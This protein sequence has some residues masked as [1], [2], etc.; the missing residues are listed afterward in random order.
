MT[1]WFTSLIICC[2]FFWMVCLLEMEQIAPHQ[3]L[4][5]SLGQCF[6]RDSVGKSCLF[7]SD[8][9]FLWFTAMPCYC[10]QAEKVIITSA[11]AAVA[12]KF[13]SKLMFSVSTW[14][15]VTGVLIIGISLLELNLGRSALK[16][17]SCPWLTAAG[18]DCLEHKDIGT[19]A[20]LLKWLLKIA[21]SW[22]GNFWRN[23][24]SSTCEFLLV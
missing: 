14:A 3:A 22:E 10:C 23:E 12:A 17:L 15:Y 24:I 8:H 11:R 9:I 7:L 1:V 4:S 6:F 13:P 16:S 5:W 21:S 18:P 20:L 2:T 19:A